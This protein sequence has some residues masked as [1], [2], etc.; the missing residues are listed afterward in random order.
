MTRINLHSCRC[1]IC[2]TSSFFIYPL[3]VIFLKHILQVWFWKV[4]SF[5]ILRGG[6]NLRLFVVFST[7]MTKL[8]WGR[9]R[10]FCYFGVQV[11]LWQTNKLRENRFVCFVNKWRFFQHWILRKPD[12]KE[13]KPISSLEQVERLVA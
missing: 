10:F 9:A 3:F 5:G 13:E 7:L 4:W 12:I 6:I 8:L 1:R 11:V 2:K